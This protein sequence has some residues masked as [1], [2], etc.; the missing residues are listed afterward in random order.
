MEALAL[1]SP[2][3]CLAAAASVI[4]LF[5]ARRREDGSAPAAWVASAGFFAAAVCLLAIRPSADEGATSV[6]DGFLMADGLGVTAAL[7]TVACGL[8]TS[9]SLRGYL[10]KIDWDYP[11]I[12][13]LL[14]FAV[15]GMIVMSMT[16]LLPGIFLGL[17]IM[18]LAL[19]A[20]TASVRKWG[21]SV[22]AGT[23]YFLTGAFA[24]GLLLFGI[25]LLYGVTGDIGLQGLAGV[26]EERDPLA[27]AGVLFVIAGFAFKVGAVPFHQ[28]VPDVYQ[29]APTPVTGFMSTAVKLAAF[30][31]LIRVVDHAAPG[32]E[33]L[34]T[35]LGWLG[36]L[37]MS[38]GNVA[39]LAQGSVKRLLAY[40]SI[41]HAG[42]V[43]LALAALAAGAEG[44]TNAA[45]FYL[46]V[47][48]VTNLG[49]FAVLSA[50]ETADG[51]G[52]EF[53]D[54][55]GLK[56]RHPVL[57]GA[58]LVLMLSLAGIPPAAGFLAKWNVFA[59]L[60]D[61]YEALG[62]AFWLFLI[63]ALVVNSLVGLAYYLRVVMASWMR[64]APDP[65]PVYP[66][67]RRLAY[68]LILIAAALSL[69]LGFGPDIL[70]LGADGILS[71]VQRSVG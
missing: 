14:L 2:L 59:V 18:S 55:G 40:S 44:G 50:I 46:V 63:L 26:I 51:G 58:L 64:P 7:C 33:S 57:A 32:M 12:H 41:A 21:T 67:P 35:G 30:A 54:L 66:T 42:Y 1:T 29:G 3:I 4:L 19:Y 6:F 71:W 61:R 28:W 48:A 27:L 5:F 22:E 38:V 25:A 65:L 11:E 13:V 10:R 17:E 8:F 24:S 60:A 52:L 9:L 47:Y 62:R 70:G 23:K 45:M 39:A 20:L 49:A 15:M 53:Q 69:W 31:A 56:D 37:T 34:A 36:V 16:A 68:A 43:L